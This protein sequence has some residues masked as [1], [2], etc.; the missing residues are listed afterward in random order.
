MMYI[1]IIAVVSILIQNSQHSTA[2]KAISIP[3]YARKSLN[4]ITYPSSCRTSGLGLNL[5][6]GDDSDFETDEGVPEEFRE[7]AA[8][9]MELQKREKKFQEQEYEEQDRKERAEEEE[10][11]SLLPKYME[12]LIKN[13]ENV[14]EIILAKPESELPT[15]AIIGRPNTGKSTIVNKL[16]NSYGDGGAIVHDEPGITRDA[17]Y[18]TG[19]WNEYNFQ[20][21]DTGGIVFDDNDDIFADRITEQAILALGSANYAVMVCDGKEGVTILDTI[22]VEWL[23][24]KCKIPIFLAVNKC[25]SE[26]VGISQAQEFWGL[27]MGNPYPVSGIHGTGLA[28]LLDDIV[29]TMEKVSNIIRQ[30]ATNVAFIGRPNVGKSSLFNKLIG[31][32]RSIVSDIAGTTR[33][34]IDQVISR[35]GQDYR[36][37]DTAGI[38]RKQKIE[39][40][41]EF[42]MINRAF[43]AV[44]RSECVVLLLD[45]ISG[46]VEQD[47]ILAS[48]IADEGKSCVIALNKWD[49]VPDKT[50]KTYLAAIENIRQSLPALRWAEIVLMSAE[51]GQ[52]TEKMFECVDRAAKQY[53]RR[54]PTSVLNE[55]VNDATLWMS[56]P[57]IGSRSGRIYYSLQI[58]TQ[59]PTIVFFVNDPKLFTDNYQRF[60]ERKLRDALKL[61]GTPIKMIWRGKSLRDITRASGKGSIDVMVPRSD[62][63][64]RGNGGRTMP[65]TSKKA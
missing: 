65:T 5:V 42:F 31:S 21:V 39:Y 1:S 62:M 23:R 49:V 19:S 2:F 43:K 63:P 20:V 26:S 47:R 16:T 55:V 13:Y 30:N 24:K 29:E 10:Y 22:L 17:T 46:I 9:E 4:T 56:P 3:H 54:I 37:I 14:T 35:N 32:E 27:G 51:T 18:R 33:D 38:R 28:E 57:T 12:R 41:A 11:E 36:I 50:D 60:L 48:R 64:S 53:S 15:I 6:A 34:A 40:G 45:A 58:S 44:K 61:D 7:W 59:P 25:E 8:E 52:R